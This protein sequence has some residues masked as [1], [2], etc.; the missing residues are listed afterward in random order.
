MPALTIAVGV[1]LDSSAALSIPN[2]KCSGAIVFTDSVPYTI[3]V[4]SYAG[5]RW[6]SYTAAANGMLVITGTGSAIVVIYAGTC[7]SLGTAFANGTLV[8][9]DSTYLVKITSLTGTGSITATNLPLLALYDMVTPGSGTTLTDVS[10]NNKNATFGFPSYGNVPTWD[11]NKGLIFDGTD[12][13]DMPNS[14][15]PPASV[16]MCALLQPASVGDPVL[17]SLVVDQNVNLWI[18]CRP[19][20]TPDWVS[21]P[22]SHYISPSERQQGNICFVS[23]CTAPGFYYGNRETLGYLENTPRTMNPDSGVFWMGTSVNGTPV[24]GYVGELYYAAYFSVAITPPQAAVVNTYIANVVAERGV[25]VGNILA[26]STKRILCHGDSLTAG[27]PLT[28]VGDWPSQLRTVLNSNP[29]IYNL[30]VAGDTAQ[31]SIATIGTLLNPLFEG[32][33]G[34]FH[35]VIEFG[36]NDLFFNGTTPA[37]TWTYLQEIMTSASAAAI[38]A[39][40]PYFPY[41]CTILPSGSVNY[42]TQTTALN[43]LIRTG[44]GFTLV[45]VENT[46]LGGPT[47][48]TQPE[49]YQN[50]DTHLTQAGY[51]VYA[52]V[53]QIALAMNGVD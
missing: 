50:D 8:A 26:A 40:V 4:P 24:S 45:D 27:V 38:A 46:V 31:N 32:S 20:G 19:D 2:T 30:G 11:V 48:N 23:N 42:V 51:G 13:I 12:V 16:A 43:T 22:G 14:I 47:G 28:T 21:S 25:T 52:G 10:G 3:A 1:G 44:T 34:A 18:T 39:G 29:A 35:H 5:P 9:N 7:G 49:Y 15:Y 33:T 41:I 36:R 6:F 53:V 37:N 17:Q